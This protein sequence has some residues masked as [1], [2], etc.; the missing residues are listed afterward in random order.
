MDLVK[1]SAA[2]GV[3]M[4]AGATT[5][6]ISVL[7]NMPAWKHITENL[8]SEVYAEN[9][10]HYLVGATDENKGWWEWSL[11][12]KLSKDKSS[13]NEKPGFGFKDVTD[14]WKNLK[15]KCGEAYKKPKGDVVSDT[16]TSDKYLERDV[17]RYCSPSVK[18][19]PSTVADKD[20]EQYK[21][22]TDVY[23]TTQKTKLISTTDESNDWFWQI[24]EDRFFGIGRYKGETPEGSSGITLADDSLFHEL[25]ESRKKYSRSTVKGTCE[26]AYGLKSTKENGK[27]TATEA[28]VLKFCS[29][30]GK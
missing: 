23:G 14:N 26:I 2:A 9:Y 6:G 4:A 21:S 25:Y 7:W 17:W 11:K 10:K 18:G 16:T 24:Q 19:K 20:T 22:K 15:D 28:N 27:P 8:T 3:F 29:L 12:N 13:E 5:Y 1:A 30:E